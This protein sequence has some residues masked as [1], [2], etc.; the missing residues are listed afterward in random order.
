MTKNYRHLPSVFIL[1]GFLILGTPDETARAE[2]PPLGWTVGR[3]SGT[4]SDANDGSV[5]PLRMLVE[6]LPGGHGL[7]ERLEVTTEGDPYVGF[8]VCLP[9]PSNQEWEKLYTNDVR[10]KFARMRAPS[11]EETRNVWLS[12]TAKPPRASRLVSERLGSDRWRRTQQTSTDGGATWK[13]VFVDELER[14]QP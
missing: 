14:E 13:T 3:W 9:D 10:P 4:R 11:V 12:V 1:L 6:R 5:A 8:S 2:G 7:I